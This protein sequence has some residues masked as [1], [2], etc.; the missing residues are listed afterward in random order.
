MAWT[1]GK[2]NNANIVK[3]MGEIRVKGNW[4]RGGLNGKW[5]G[6]IEEYMHILGMW[7]K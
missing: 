2:K 7:S 6:I 5:I 1:F 4:I 3:K